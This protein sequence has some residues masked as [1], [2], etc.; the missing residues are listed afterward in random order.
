MYASSGWLAFAVLLMA[1]G[2]YTWH[3]FRVGDWVKARLDDGDYLELDED[4]FNEFLDCCGPLGVRSTSLHLNQPLTVEYVDVL[5]VTVAQTVRWPN[6]IFYLVRES[7]YS[8][9][10]E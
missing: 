6:R 4:E 8:E 3:K 5:G 9:Y 2:Y 10:M 7:W 1:F